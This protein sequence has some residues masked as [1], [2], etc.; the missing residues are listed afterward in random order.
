MDVEAMA[1]ERLF[2]PLGIADVRWMRGPDGVMPP[3]FGLELRPRDLLKLGQLVLRG[4]EWKGR[5]VLSEGWIAEALQIRIPKD[6]VNG[7]AGYGYLWWIR[8]VEV[9]GRK[10]RVHYAWGVGGQYL[11]VVPE[12]DLA[13][14]V[15]GGNYKNGKLG[16]NGFRI[17]EEHLLP[18]FL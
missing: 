5:R 14:L 7:R 11:L 15:L 3:A 16:T 13:V 6:K 12:L 10:F 17:F 1:R 8:D 18:A 2:D 4:G 9:K